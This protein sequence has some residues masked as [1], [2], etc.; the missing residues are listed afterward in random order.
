MFVSRKRRIFNHV[1][2]FF[3]LV[4]LCY[5][6]KRS[7]SETKRHEENNRPK[8]F[9]ELKRHE[10]EFAPNTEHETTTTQLSGSLDSELKD[11]IGT[12]YA[13]TDTSPT[14]VTKS[15]R[16]NLIE[17]QS[18]IMALYEKPASSQAFTS[19]GFNS[20]ASDQKSLL[21]ETIDYSETC[22]ERYPTSDLPS[23]SIIITFFNEHWTTLWAS[24]QKISSVIFPVNLKT[25]NFDLHKIH[26]SPA[27]TRKH[28]FILYGSE[29]FKLGYL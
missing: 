12:T 13:P 6:Y 10:N 25:S 15:D 24:A 26:K 17:I 19:F 16:E 29:I 1:R 4:F 18:G 8:F 5:C 23:A 2:N 9:A 14:L 11:E 22:A 20:T 28:R 7:L 27:L 21:P 3:I